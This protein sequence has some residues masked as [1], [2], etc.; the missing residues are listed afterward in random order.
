MGIHS[1]GKSSCCIGFY[2]FARDSAASCIPL[3]ASIPAG[4]PAFAYR[5][6]V[7]CRSLQLP[8]YC[9]CWCPF[10]N[11]IP[12]FCKRHCIESSVTNDAD[13]PDLANTVPSF[14][15]QSGVSAFNDV[16]AILMPS[17]S[18]KLLSFFLFHDLLSLLLLTLLLPMQYL[19]SL[20]FL[21]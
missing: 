9:C 21:P 4:I 5:T 1:V 8:A 20:L 19:L 16:P 10:Y 6:I 7:N 12:C 18:Q 2:D 3:V 15:I 14:P 17:E 11:E 13:N